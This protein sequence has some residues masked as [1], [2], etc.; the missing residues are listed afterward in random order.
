VILLLVVVEEHKK[1]H[2][3]TFQL[4]YAVGFVFVGFH[5]ATVSKLKAALTKRENKTQKQRK[6]DM[7]NPATSCT[8]LPV[9]A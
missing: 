6:S 4:P 3:Y 2:P 8:N 9:N 5:C 7:R 1:E